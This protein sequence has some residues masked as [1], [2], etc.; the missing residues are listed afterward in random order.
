M[1]QK[2]LIDSNTIIDLIANRLTQT[3]ANFVYPI[4]DED[5]T[6][7]VIT[8]IEVLGFNEVPHKIALLEEL[9]SNANIIQL[10][11]NVTNKTIEIRRNKK[12]K[13]GDAIIAATALTHNLTLITRNA[14]DFKNI[15]NLN[16][17][18]PDEL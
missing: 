5:F 3:A 16:I 18:N 13:L 17:I 8:K 15:P 9:I 14:T 7:S 11:D 1:G 10:T 4:F 12:M 2:F 6:I